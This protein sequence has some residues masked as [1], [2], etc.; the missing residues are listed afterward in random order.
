MNGPPIFPGP[1][2]PEIE[3]L[4]TSGIAA[5]FGLGFGREN[6]IPLWVGEGDMPTPAFICDAAAAA[7][8]TGETF[9][10]H[11]RGLPELR[12]AL[13]GYGEGLYARPLAADRISVVSSGM[14]AIVLAL[15]TMIRPG[16]RVAVLTPVWPN[17]LSAI[18]IAGGA[19]EAV[20]L[21]PREDGGF[22]LDLDRLL[23]VVASGV[24]AVFVASPGNPTGWVMDREEQAA[25][26]EACRRRGVW[27]IADEVYARLV[28]DRSVAPSF[29][30]L[31]GDEDPLIVIN[32]FSKAWA[33]TGWRM[34]WLTHPPKLAETFD[35]LIEFATS[36]APAF[37]Q[38]GCLAAIQDGEPLIA[39][40]LER[41]RQGREIVFQ[42]LSGF[43]RVRAAR[44]RG[45][46]YAFFPVK[47][48]TDSLAFAKQILE[49]TGV[50]LAPGSAFGPGGEGHLRLCFASGAESLSEALDRLEPLL[51]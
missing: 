19:V 11:K 39:E 49:K 35:R 27:I 23:G 50:G 8:K 26:L 42:R 31:A 41:C 38:R 28:Y 10:T 1:L 40:V 17:I 44:P 14:T 24:R 15:Q 13:A 7:L 9:Y 36:G 5:L 32:S 6:L 12:Q 43:S 18:G 29:L 3:A 48:L 4:E 2:R 51:S 45:A 21:E 34:G 25:L 20:P 33:M 37:L 46:F 16:D 30:E 22:H 47:G